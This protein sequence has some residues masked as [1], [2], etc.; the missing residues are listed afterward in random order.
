MVLLL[1]SQLVLRMLRYD[2]QFRK[3]LSP[4]RPSGLEGLKASSPSVLVQLLW[5]I[6][7]EA[8]ST[9]THLKRN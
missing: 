6:E 1:L 2:E 4:L 9:M 5:E 7:I 8:L 3:P